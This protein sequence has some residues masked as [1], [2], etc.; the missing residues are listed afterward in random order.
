MKWG[1]SRVCGSGFWGGACVCKTIKQKVTFKVAPEV[2]YGVLTDAKKLSV[3][4]EK[5]ALIS[6]S[7]GGR[8]SI[9]AGRIEGINVDFSPPYRIV[10]A[11]RE[12]QF[13]QGVFS[14][15]SFQLNRTPNG[16]TQLILTH[17][18]VPKELIPRIERHWRRDYWD[19]MK[20]YFATLV[21]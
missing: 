11:W 2:V 4:S 1:R 12:A 20:S 13:P 16:G 15:A 7:V 18:G 6:E 9:F 19:K 21:I 3:L 14:M 5:K 17:R 10:Q 8:F